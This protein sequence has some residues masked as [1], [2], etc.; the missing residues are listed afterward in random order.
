[1]FCQKPPH[2]EDPTAIYPG[3][4]RPLFVYFRSN[5]FS[6]RKVWCCCL[7]L[8]PESLSSLATQ[9]LPPLVRKFPEQ[10]NG[11]AAINCDL[12]EC[13]SLPEPCIVGE[14]LQQSCCPNTIPHQ[15]FRI[16]IDAQII[17]FRNLWPSR[18]T[19]LQ[20]M[21]NLALHEV[22]LGEVLDH[23]T[24]KITRFPTITVPVSRTPHILST[25][26]SFHSSL[27]APYPLPLHASAPPPGSTHPSL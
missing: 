2:G 8:H 14:Q 16:A 15:T 19:I 5:C 21:V 25:I 1:M 3:Q 6:V 23:N 9:I 10:S 12:H 17:I 27:R 11:A 7:Q 18:T 13:I 24:S 22:M 20:F 26:D 4:R